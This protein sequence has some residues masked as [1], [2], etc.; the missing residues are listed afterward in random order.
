MFPANKKWEYILIYLSSNSKHI[1]RSCN[2]YIYN[3]LSDIEADNRYVTLYFR[4]IDYRRYAE[5]KLTLIPLK[6]NEKRHISD[7][8]EMRLTEEER[9]ELVRTE[10]TLSIN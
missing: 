5:G 9:G 2:N 1:I 8:Y 10:S 6:S 7:L 3:Y 4:K